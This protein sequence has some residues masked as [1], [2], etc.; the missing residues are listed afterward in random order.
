MKLNKCLGISIQR[1]RIFCTL[2]LVTMVGQCCTKFLDKKNDG[3]VSVPSSVSDMQS[4]L[5]YRTIINLRAPTLDE[6]SADDY[7]LATNT[8]NGMKD[9]QQHAYTWTLS[10][11]D[12]DNS[13]GTRNDYSQLYDNVNYANI[14]IDGLQDKSTTEGQEVLGQAYFLR[15]ISFFQLM[16]LFAQAYVPNSTNEAPGIILKLGSSPNYVAKR[17]SVGESMKQVVDDL[18]EAAGLMW[19]KD[20]VPTRGSKCAALGYLSRVYLYMNQYDS[21]QKYCDFSLAMHSQLMDYNGSPDIT[22]NATVPFKIFNSETL[23]YY[24]S[25]SYIFTNSSP[26]YAKVNPELLALYEDADLRKTLYF[27]GTNGNVSFKGTYGGSKT[28]LFKGLAVDELYLIRAECLARNNGKEEASKCLDTLLYK[29]YQTGKFSG[30]SNLDRT[31]LLDRILVERRKE[32]SFRSVRW[33]DIKRLNVVGANITLKRTTE[34]GSYNLLANSAYYALP[35][36]QYIV[37]MT[38]IKQNN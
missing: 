14:V 23:Y 30:T 10:G 32:L 3:T 31:E 13:Y 34:T 16:G 4:I 25:S 2:V 38:G 24:V 9:F 8:L 28:Y 35:F 33:G 22:S 1:L 27:S 7:V 19:K 21:A 29:R 20:V 17:S 11:I 26:S 5:D 36:P 12:M 37:D 15:G 6:A 18:K